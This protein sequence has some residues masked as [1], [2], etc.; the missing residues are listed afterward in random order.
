MGE[1]K[2]PEINGIIIAGR[3]LRIVTGCC[4]DVI[5]RAL[6]AAK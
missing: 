6:S 5:M 2:K 3:R 1:I 4:S